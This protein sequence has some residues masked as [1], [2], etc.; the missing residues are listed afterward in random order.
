MISA[1]IK[2]ST[3]RVRDQTIVDYF[4]KLELAEDA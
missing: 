2:S 1:P 3:E 4:P